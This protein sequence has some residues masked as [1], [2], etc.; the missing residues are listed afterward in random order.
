VTEKRKRRWY[1]FSLRALLVFVLL[2]SIGMSWLAVRRQ[3]VRR[4]REDAT[5]TNR[6]VPNSASRHRGAGRCS[7]R[8]FSIWTVA[9]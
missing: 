4:Q 2:V 8:A 6:S 1:Q 3:R 9:P 7:C 5:V